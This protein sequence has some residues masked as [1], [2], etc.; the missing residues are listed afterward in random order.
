MA[1]VKV[2]VLAA[3]VDGKGPDSLITIDERSAF[4]LVSQG[5][6]ELIGAAETKTVAKSVVEDKAEKS[7]KAEVVA[8]ESAPKTTTKPRKTAASRKK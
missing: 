4:A 6:V 2:R 1:Q 3:N 8:K 5:Y 7:A